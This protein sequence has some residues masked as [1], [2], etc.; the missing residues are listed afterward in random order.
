MEF[1]GLRTAA[2]AFLIVL[3]VIGVL[4]AGC[5]GPPTA[6]A[7]ITAAGTAVPSASSR[8]GTAS[9]VARLADSTREW[10]MVVLGDST[11]DD[12]D[13]FPFLAAQQLGTVYNRPVIV[14]RWADSRGYAEDMTF[15]KTVDAEP[16]HLWNGS[17]SGSIGAY[18][19]NHLGAMAPAGTD[20]VLI[21]YGHNYAGPQQAEDGLSRLLEAVDERLGHPPVLVTIQNPKN[22]ETAVSSAIIAQVRATAAAYSCGTVDV[23]GAFR[24]AGDIGRLLLDDTHPSRAGSKIWADAVVKA[25]S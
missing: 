21:N 17:V 6:P 15:P 5:A 14:H 19:A 8:P 4:A 18:A 7:S 3:A 1:R 16:I 11:G 12:P 25:L 24:A 22:P 10:N 9:S 13:E 20:L 23:H 2:A